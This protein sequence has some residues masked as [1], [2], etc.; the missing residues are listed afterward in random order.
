VSASLWLW[1]RLRRRL[2]DRQKAAREYRELQS[3]RAQLLQGVIRL[4]FLAVLVQ[5]VLMVGLAVAAAP[6]QIPLAI[7]VLLQPLSILF[8]VLGVGIAALALRLLVLFVLRQWVSNLAVPMAERARREQRYHNLLQASQR[9]IDLAFVTVLAV[10]V[11]LDIPGVRELTV[12]A[13]LAGGALLGG[14]AIA[15]QGLLRDLVA[16]LV[17]LLDDHYAVGDVVE[18]NG[19]TGEVV[20]LGLLVTELRTAD[21][22][23][24]VV[25]NSASQQL[26][27]HTKIRS[28]VDVVI[29]LSPHN[30][31]LEEALAL[32][33][34]ECTVFAADP[35]TGVALLQAPSVRGV[36]QVTPQAVE[37]SVLLTTHTGEQWAAER[38]LLR[39]LVVSLQE[40]GIPLASATLAGKT[41]L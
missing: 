12:G 23:V 11:L 17:A 18:I 10:L 33:E 39:R 34:A 28:G 38:A 31:R 14:L 16:G 37:I 4:L 8:K 27:N 19:V 5:L 22:R 40:A 20:D 15:F 6:G 41:T 9:L 21:Q 30:T 1:G 29:P 7:T 25:A 3:S 13:W 36:S 32:I 24:V 2:R 26:L 35:A